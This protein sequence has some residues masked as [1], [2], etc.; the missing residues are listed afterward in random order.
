MIYTDAQYILVL[1]R[2]IAI[3]MNNS[4]IENSY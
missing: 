1:I 4:K 3:C 2:F